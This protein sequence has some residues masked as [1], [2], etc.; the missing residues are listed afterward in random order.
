MTDDE[1]VVSRAFCLK[2]VAD[3]LRGAAEFRQR[4]DIMVGRFEAA[5]LEFD[6][7]RSRCIKQILQLFDVG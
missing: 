2:S 7:G 6:A 4:M 1:S 5:N 3:R